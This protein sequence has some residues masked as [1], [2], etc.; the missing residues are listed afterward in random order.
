MDVADRK[1]IETIKYR[2]LLTVKTLHLA[3]NANFNCKVLWKRRK[4]PYMQIK[5]RPRRRLCSI[6]IIKV[7]STN[8]CNWNS[9]SKE[10]PGA[11]FTLRKT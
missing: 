4:E 1:N 11:E 10:T 9:T 7:S 2:V 6:V 5:Q 3:K 8:S